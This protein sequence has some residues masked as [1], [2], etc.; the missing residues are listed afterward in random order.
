MHLDGGA[1]DWT[2]VVPVRDPRTGKSRLG[3]G[4]EINAAIAHDTLSA[5]LACSE[6]RQLVL[7]TDDPWWVD[8]TLLAHPRLTLVVH[9]EPGLNS[10]VASGLLQAERH[11]AVLLGDLPCLRPADLTLALTAAR[12]I[13]RGMVRDRH[14]TGTTLLTG[15]PHLPHFGPGSAVR[16][17]DAGYQELPLP[18]AATVS[19]DVDTAQD[20]LEA[21]R[22]FGVGPHTRRALARSR[23]LSV[24]GAHTSPP[25]YGMHTAEVFA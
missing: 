13:P 12:D 20:L 5:A 21:A 8:E 7:V 14:G 22:R 17:R 9:R 24:P 25:R 23:T 1:A 18:R 19:H 3:A 4:P 10:A 16:H 2:A 6:I 15:G 11:A